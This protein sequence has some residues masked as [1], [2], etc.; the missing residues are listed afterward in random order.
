MRR[1]LLLAPLI[2]LNA[3]SSGDIQ[4]ETDMGEKII[5]KAKSVS[6]SPELL[7]QEQLDYR[8][9]RAESDRESYLECQGYS[10]PVDC[11]YDKKRVSEAEKDVETYKKAQ[12]LEKVVG[13]PIKGTVKFLPIFED[14]LGNQEVKEARYF[15]CANPN[16]E[17]AKDALI[18]IGRS[19]PSINSNN[20]WVLAGAKACEKYAKFQ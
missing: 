9:E 7:S 10:F 1:L 8:L 17:G 15:T 19:I 11:S 4:V 18:A 16:V 12:E 2:L 6:F 3:C 13:V 5:V 14:A 20:A